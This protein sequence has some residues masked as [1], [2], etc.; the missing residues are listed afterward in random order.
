MNTDALWELMDLIVLA[1]GVYALYGAWALKSRGKIIKTFLVFKD[2]D[3]NSCRDLQAY[4]DLM[5]PKLGT[6]GLV[7]VLYGVIAVLNA[8][9]LDI[10]TLYMVFTVIFVLVLIWYGIEVKKAMNRYF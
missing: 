3:V 2:T 8:H 4:A 9:V 7:M 1:C 6:L 5:S 10:H